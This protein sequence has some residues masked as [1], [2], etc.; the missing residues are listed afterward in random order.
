[1][2]KV[3]QE[4]ETYRHVYSNPSEWIHWDPRSILRATEIGPDGLR[5]FIKGDWATGGLAY[6]V[7]CQSLLECL[8]ILDTQFSLELDARLSGISRE[9]IAILNQAVASSLTDSGN[10]EH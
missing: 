10:Q 6:P 5:G 4:K 7:A 2:F 9:M 1:M 8:Q 3:L